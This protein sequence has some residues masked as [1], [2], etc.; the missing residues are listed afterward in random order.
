VYYLKVREKVNDPKILIL[1]KI[2]NQ[3]IESIQGLLFRSP[4]GYY[5]LNHDSSYVPLEHE[6]CDQTLRKR[7]R[8][9]STCDYRMISKFKFKINF[10][11]VIH[12]ATENGRISPKLVLVRKVKHTQSQDISDCKFRGRVL[13]L[14]V[15]RYLIYKLNHQFYKIKF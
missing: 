15:E 1:E 6:S 12:S 2:E 11:L 3:R 14:G 8:F 9:D 4:I 13:I 7:E 5:S 10:N